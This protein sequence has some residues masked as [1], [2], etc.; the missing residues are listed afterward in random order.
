MWEAIRRDCRWGQCYVT[1]VG[2]PDIYEEVFMCD[3]DPLFTGE[4]CNVPKSD[5]EMVQ[6]MPAEAKIVAL[7]G[8]IVAIL[9]IVMSIALIWAAC[10]KKYRRVPSN[11]NA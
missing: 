3:C 2:G 7:I 11:E 1:Q 5:W 10:T 4:I 6:I 8:L 9:L